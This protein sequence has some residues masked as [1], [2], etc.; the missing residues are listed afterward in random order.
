M[1]IDML[2][3]VSAA[4]NAVSSVT[5]AAGGAANTLKVGTAGSSF[6]DTLGKLVKSVEKTTADANAA[7]SNMLD[8][9]G[10]VHE[11]MIALQRAEMTFQLTV[12]VRNKLMSAY[13]EIMRMPI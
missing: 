7:T 8:K 5:P 4:A 2:K 12:Q 3:A 13:S 9:T 6:A 1:P 10:D 11:A